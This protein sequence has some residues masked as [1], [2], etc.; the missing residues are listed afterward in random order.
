MRLIL[1]GALLL[2]APARLTAQ[3]TRHFAFNGHHV[4]ELRSA[5]APW[6]KCANE[7]KQHKSMCTRH[8]ERVENVSVDVGYTFMNDRLSGVSFL[9]D[10]VGFDGIL[11]AMIK[12]YGEP[13]RLARARGRDYAEWRFKEGRLYL[14]RTGSSANQ[15]VVATFAAE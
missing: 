11:P 4:G 2:A 10:S 5:G 8:H 12:R 13:A 7:P 1:L 9:V 14:T 3:A 15:V 6:A